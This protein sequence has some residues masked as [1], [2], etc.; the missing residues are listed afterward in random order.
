MEG[1]KECLYIL[2][3]TSHTV[4]VYRYIFH[5][6][7]LNW[8]SFAFTMNQWKW[9]WIP[10]AAPATLALIYLAS[11]P[12]ARNWSVPAVAVTA[13][14]WTSTWVPPWPSQWVWVPEWWRWRLTCCPEKLK[15]RASAKVRVGVRATGRVGGGAYVELDTPTQRPTNVIIAQCNVI[16]PNGHLHRDRGLHWRL[17][18][19]LQTN[20]HGIQ[21]KLW[22][23][24][25]LYLSLSHSFSVSV[26]LYLNFL[27]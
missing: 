1:E 20:C 12:T 25:C 22:G 6:P 3:T 13:W 7:S 24:V 16:A 10:L 4:D 8:L 26:C 18:S 23:S 5:L 2:C 15:K 14:G 9:E 11:F 21:L 27:V 19:T 17:Q